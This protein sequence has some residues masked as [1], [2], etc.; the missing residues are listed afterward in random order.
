MYQI[1]LPVSKETV[2][3]RAY[4]VREEKLLLIAKEDS[5]PMQVNLALN[6]IISNC[7]S[8][9]EPEQLCEADR[10]YILIQFKSKLSGNIEQSTY[11]C[12]HEKEDGTECGGLL[13]VDVDLDQIKL[14]EPIRESLFKLTPTI[15]VKF[16]IPTIEDTDKVNQSVYQLEIDREIEMMYCSLEFIFERDDVTYKS[17][18]ARDEFEMWLLDLPSPQ[19]D[20]ISDFF[21]HLPKLAYDT[22]VKCPSCGTEHQ[23]HIEG[24]NSFFSS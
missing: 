7:S 23:I 18:I 19:Y 15:G 6:Q 21:K 1:T 10:D 24:L 4:T 5:N 8:V 11:I 16:R 17:D 14:I 20:T 12:K 13:Q 2:S 22:T 9:K 3:F